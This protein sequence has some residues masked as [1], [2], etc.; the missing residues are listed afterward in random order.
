MALRKSHIFED[1][2]NSSHPLKVFI[3]SSAEGLPIAK[4]LQAEIDSSSEFESHC[5]T[6]GT[7]SPGSFTLDALVEKAHVVDFAILVATGEDTVI[8][9]GMEM[10]AIRDNIVFEFGLFLGALGRDRVYLLS[11][12]DVK[13][14]SDLEGLFRLT[15]K[16]RSDSNIRAGLNNAVLQAQEAMRRH[17][18]R[19]PRMQSTRVEAGAIV[20]QI[21]HD[22]LT[23]EST[24]PR[25]SAVKK[26]ESEKTAGEPRSNFLATAHKEHVIKAL[27]EEIRWLCSNAENQGW[28]LVKN[29]LTML[30]LRSPKGK[31][32]TL[33]RKRSAVTR[34]ELRSFVAELRANGLRV[35]QAL[36]GAVEDSP[37][38]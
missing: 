36:Q 8:T 26:L 25:A 23:A 10:A 32:F 7:F 38:G 4:N 9:R 3:G 24:S 11:V 19:T 14:P 31:E 33:Y 22:A 29:N 6:T 30:R 1:M 2:K 13:V 28:S 15:Y 37:F 16:A 34:I 18:P 27:E 21:A 35:N 17:G 12:G 5:W 20:E